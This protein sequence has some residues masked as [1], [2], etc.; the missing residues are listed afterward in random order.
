MRHWAL[1]VRAINCLTHNNK[2]LF[3]NGLQPHRAAV[4]GAFSPVATTATQKRARIVRQ[5]NNKENHRLA[6][7]FKVCRG[8]S[9]RLNRVVSYRLTVKLGKS[10]IAVIEIL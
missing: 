4:A 2:T 10:T 9:Q 1:N 3:F 8:A 6:P 5:E 7:I